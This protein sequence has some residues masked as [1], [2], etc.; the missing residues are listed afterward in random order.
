MRLL[1]INSVLGFG[2]TG[3][4]VLDIARE[5]EENGYEVKIAYGRKATDSEEG[6]KYGVRI[7]NYSDVY[8]HVLYTRL[9][10]KHGLASKG[11]TKRFLK[12]ADEYDPDVL[13]LHNIHDYYINYEDLFKWIKS[14]PQMEVKW[15]LHDCWAFTGHCSHFAYA[16]CDKWR[17]GCGNCLQLDQYPKSIVDNSKRN[18]KRKKATFSGVSNLTI[19]TPSSWLKN[20]VKDSFLSEYPVEVVYN[21][22]DT[23]LFKPTPST[24][25]ADHGI[26]DKKMILG[27]A[28]VWNDRKGLND[29]IELSKLIDADTYKIVLV[30]LF[31]NQIDNLK[32]VAPSILAL[33]RTSNA[34]ELVKIY[35]ASDV[36]VNPTYE[37]TFPTVNMEA[38]ACGTPVITYDTCGCAETIKRSDSIVIE[39][40]VKALYKQIA[41]VL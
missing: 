6:K 20:L 28:N 8:Y 40:D 11:A 35:S 33:P 38:E 7:G 30:G 21:K 14:R 37:D 24:F 1:I 4:I 34:G 23:N 9:T 5:Y 31:E 3:K 41:E 22:I 12:W 36:F 10:D 26:Q 32:E 15:T 25:K 29:F 2:S 18:F 39:Q 17:S 19:V 16:K 27:V 13:W